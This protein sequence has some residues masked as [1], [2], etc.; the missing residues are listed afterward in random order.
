MPT[1]LRVGIYFLKN[2]SSFD[3]WASGSGYTRISIGALYRTSFEYDP[4]KAVLINNAL[5]E[6]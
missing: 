2:M 1:F 5:V 4:S 3:Y 6:S